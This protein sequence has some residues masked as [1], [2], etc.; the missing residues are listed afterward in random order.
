MRWTPR[1]TARS[2]GSLTV[3]A[4]PDSMLLVS[5]KPS[6]SDRPKPGDHPG[7]VRVRAHVSADHLVRLPSEIPEGPVELIVIPQPNPTA[8]ARRAAFG[9]YDGSGFTVPDDFDAPLPDDVLALFEGGPTSP[10]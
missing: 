9:R 8:E 1:W 2:G 3:L 10:R 5:S 7:A 4:I 6:K